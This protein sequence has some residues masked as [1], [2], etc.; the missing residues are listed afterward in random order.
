MK[1][2]P[3]DWLIAA[4]MFLTFVP[5]AVLATGVF[6]AALAFVPGPT[7][8]YLKV[9]AAAFALGGVAMIGVIYRTN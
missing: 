1:P 7:L 6:A 5:Y 3:S 9:F 2:E 8:A 4:T